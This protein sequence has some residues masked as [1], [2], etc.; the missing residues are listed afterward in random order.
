MHKQTAL[1]TCNDSQQI[2]ALAF[3]TQFN[4]TKRSLKLTKTRRKAWTDSDACDEQWIAYN[5][6]VAILHANLQAL[7]YLV[8]NL[9]HNET[10]VLDSA[11]RSKIGAVKADYRRAIE[12]T[13]MKDCEKYH[14]DRNVPVETT[15]NVKVSFQDKVDVIKIDDDYIQGVQFSLPMIC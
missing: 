13:W 12:E 2:S 3:Q 15:R 6:S 8:Y 10:F 11:M 1:E 9:E 14:S 5:D 4:T 7:L